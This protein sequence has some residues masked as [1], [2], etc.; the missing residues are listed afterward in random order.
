M[1][2]VSH[3]RLEKLRCRLDRHMT[4]GF[5]QPLLDVV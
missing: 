2:H 3:G 1:V 4:T 5:S